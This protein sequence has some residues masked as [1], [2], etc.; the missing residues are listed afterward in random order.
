MMDELPPHPHF[1]KRKFPH[2]APLDVPIWR[3]FLL[4]PPVVFEEIHYDVALGGLASAA[5]DPQHG[6]LP[7]WGNLLKKRVDVVCHAGECR[8]IIEVKPVANMEALGQVLAYDFLYRHFTGW[9]GETRKAVVCSRADADLAG[10]YDAYGV[11]AFVCAVAV[12]PPV[13]AP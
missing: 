6:L 4:S 13:L 10:V 9:A 1:D 12:V 2:M 3:R 5:I 8:W 7:M 11:S